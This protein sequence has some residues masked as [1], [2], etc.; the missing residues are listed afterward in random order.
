MDKTTGILIARFQ[1][2]YLHEGHVAIIDHVSARHNKVVIVLG[3]TAVKGSKRNPYDFYTREKMVKAAYPDIVLLPLSDHPSDKVWSQNLD[4]LLN[5][6]F[7]HEKMVLYGSRDSFIP[8]YDG[9]FTTEEFP[10]TGD[11]SAS[12]IRFEISD[13][14]RSSEDFRAGI[15][16]AVHNQYA[17]VYP[18]VDVA[19][20]RKERSEVLLGQK[21]TLKQWRIPGGFVDPTD[22][23]YEDAGKREL[24]EECGAI[25]TGAFHYEGSF[26]VDDWRYRSEEDKIITTLYSTELTFGNAQAGDDLIELGWFR[27]EELEQ[28]M[29]EG[30]IVA[31]HHPLIQRLLENNL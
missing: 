8:Y 28:M 22:H 10:Q 3:V 27:L 16:Y 13:R 4:Q 26:Q 1:T 20:F 11:Y 9:Q 31:E 23:S 7:G 18:T 17:K 6:T 12:D 5:S 29:K 14:V 15:N 21:R 2:P 30:Q 24:Q 19:V 25:E